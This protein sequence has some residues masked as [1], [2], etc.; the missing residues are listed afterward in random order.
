MKRVERDDF[1]RE[2]TEYVVN[3][4]DEEQLRQ[5]AQINLLANINPE[6]TYEEWEDYVA[7]MPSENTVEDLLELIKPS[8]MLRKPPNAG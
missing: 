1:I 5:I 4:M 7:Q 3:K 8:M 6:S 2:Y